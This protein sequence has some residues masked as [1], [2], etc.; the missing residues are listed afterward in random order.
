MKILVISDTHRKISRARVVCEKLKDL[1]LIIHLGDYVSDALRLS[2]DVDTK[3]ITVPGNMDQFDFEMEDGATRE[4]PFYKVID[5]EFGKL[6]L[7]HGH[8]DQ[9]KQIYGKLITKA[10]EQDCKAV[11]FGHTHKPLFI[12]IDGIYLVNP[13]SI[14][15]PR[16]SRYGSYALI[17]T[18]QAEFNCAIVYDR[19]FGSG[20]SECGVGVRHRIRDILNYS[21]RF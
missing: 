9:V 12:N 5:T 17:N 18:T 21:D 6:L 19:D 3:I 8:N 2:G 10:R 16:G 11:L 20:G 13:G 4:E 15:V 7:T 14:S 1:D